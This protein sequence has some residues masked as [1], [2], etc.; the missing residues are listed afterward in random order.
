MLAVVV[1][2][3]EEFDWAQPFSRD[4]RSTATI[5]AQPAAHRIFDRL[6]VRPTYVVDHP[7]ASDPA[8]VA[9]LQG[10]VA[11]GT[12]EIG[13]QLHT[14]VTP[15]FGDAMETHESF[16]C[17]LPRAAERAKIEVLTETIAH[18]FRARPRIFKAGRYGFGPATAAILSD[19]G[20]EIDCSFVPHTGFERIGG[21]HF[22]G[23]PTAPFWLDRPGGLLEI[24]LT[25]GF[26][27]ALRGLGPGMAR[28]FDA[29][30]AR[31]LH[32]PGM[33]AR[34]GILTRARLSPENATAEEL[35]RLIDASAA[36]GQRVF[37]LAYHS[38]SLVPGHTPYVRSAA[39]L[40]DFLRRIETV[41]LHFR[42]GLGGTFTTLADIRADMIARKA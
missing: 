34:S 37:T 4:A 17:N 7:V 40:E 16:Q 5:A 22:Y 33:L 2:T 25:S 20:Y 24:P 11:A 9:V 41:L 38:P 21:P 30:T 36:T 18:A 14:W 35:C 1:D 32:I 31:R 23:R 19:L 42:D 15:P 27:G 3:E 10:F 12:A 13:A 8:A 39:D 29:P 6:G 26:Y 28:L